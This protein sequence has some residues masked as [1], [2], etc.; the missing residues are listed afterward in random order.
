MSLPGGYRADNQPDDQGN[1]A[2]AHAGPPIREL[3]A[4]RRDVL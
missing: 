3:T 4:L 1:R 2:N